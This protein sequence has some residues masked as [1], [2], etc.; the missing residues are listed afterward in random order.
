M[1]FLPVNEMTE[2]VSGMSAPN[3]GTDLREC[4]AQSWFKV[5]SVFGYPRG[6]MPLDM[7]YAIE[8]TFS[9]CRKSV[10]YSSLLNPHVT[11]T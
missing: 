4:E 11:E 10:T 6:Y 9:G 8:P 5:Q 3:S 7:L 1:C 2:P